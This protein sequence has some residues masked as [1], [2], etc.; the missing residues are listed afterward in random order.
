MEPR[1][2]HNFAALSL[3][4][5]VCGQRWINEC[6]HCKTPFVERGQDPLCGQILF[7]FCLS[8]GNITGSVCFWNKLVHFPGIPVKFHPLTPAENLNLFWEKENNR[9][10]HV[11]SWCKIPLNSQWPPW[12]LCEALTLFI[13]SG[14]EYFSL[15]Y[16]CLL[17]HA[18]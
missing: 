7:E 13:I 3:V 15:S 8:C 12:A 10:K 4:G 16:W 17:P 6:D 18:P 14:F 5:N 9:A 2:H 1:V 11:R